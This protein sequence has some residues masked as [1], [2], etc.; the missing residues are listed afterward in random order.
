MMMFRY[1]FIT[2][3]V[4]YTHHTVI[5]RR[6]VCAIM[7]FAAW[8]VSL[9]ISCLPLLGWRAGTEKVGFCFFKMLNN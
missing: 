3:N 2:K 4:R 8:T 1:W 6:T 5:P 9:L 7:M